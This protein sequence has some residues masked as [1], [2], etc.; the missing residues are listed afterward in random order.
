MSAKEIAKL[1]AENNALRLAQHEWEKDKMELEELRAENDGLQSDLERA[2][3]AMKVM[4]AVAE[5][6]LK[7]TGERITRLIDW[8]QQREPWIAQV[9]MAYV[10]GGDLFKAVDELVTFDLANPPPKAK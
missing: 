5:D 9:H 2:R 3:A 1:L 4:K 10:D 8:A 7:Q 6:G